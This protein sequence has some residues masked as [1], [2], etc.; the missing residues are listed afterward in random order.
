MRLRKNKLLHRIT[1]LKSDKSGMAESI[2]CA[3][4][5]QNLLA[6]SKMLVCKKNLK[7]GKGHLKDLNKNFYWEIHR[8]Q[9]HQ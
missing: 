1:E 7:Q 4:K 3:L 8:M 5:P 2:A 9:N 6:K